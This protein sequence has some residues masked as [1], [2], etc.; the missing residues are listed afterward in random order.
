D[1]KPSALTAACQRARARLDHVDQGKR[2]R[3]HLHAT[4]QLSLCLA[5]AGHSDE[6]QRVLR[7]A[8]RT[9]AAL[10]LSRLIIDE[11]PQIVRLA[12]DAAI[13]GLRDDTPANVRDFV[14]SLAEI[15]SL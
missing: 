4:I 9:C 5:V 7:P 2:P 13:E 6:A 8:L 12:Q 11:G 10:G 14:L 1:G 15:S 3:A